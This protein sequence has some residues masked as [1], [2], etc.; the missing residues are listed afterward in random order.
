M[1]NSTLHSDH[2]EVSILCP[3]SPKNQKRQEKSP[4]TIKVL[5]SKLTPSLQYHSDRLL[6]PL[7]LES[8]NDRLKLSDSRW[9]N[10]SIHSS[11]RHFSYDTCLLSPREDLSGSMPILY[12]GSVSCWELRDLTPSSETSTHQEDGVAAH[13]MTPISKSHAASL[14]L[15][16]RNSSRNNN[17]P[18]SKK[19]K[20][21]IVV[22]GIILFG[23]SMLL[24][25][26]T[27]RLAP[28]IDD[29]GKLHLTQIL[30]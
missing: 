9:T 6:R 8:R 11:D 17:K 20:W 18:L 7:S 19:A 16:A 1:A 5:P 10:G 29:M 25:G 22:I 21:L 12:S 28:M 30:F 24:V 26:I 3:P 15:A 2:L 4:D 14:A 23:M 13:F 27:L